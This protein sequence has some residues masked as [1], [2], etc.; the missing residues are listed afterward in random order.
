VEKQFVDLTAFHE[1]PQASAVIREI[2]AKPRKSL[3]AQ[4]GLIAIAE[5]LIVLKKQQACWQRTEQEYKTRIHESMMIEEQH[6]LPALAAAHSALTVASQDHHNLSL[7]QNKLLT[8]C[9]T[10]EEHRG[11]YDRLSKIAI[12]LLDIMEALK[13]GRTS[14]KVCI[15][16]QSS[17]GQSTD[18]NLQMYLMFLLSV[19][20]QL[21]RRY[22]DRCCPGAARLEF[23]GK[24]HGAQPS[25]SC[26]CAAYHDSLPLQPYDLFPWPLEDSPF[27]HQS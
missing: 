21:A 14:E 22:F 6:L 20:S 4:I 18:H 12:I 27:W 16:F 7:P 9:N 25:P 8:T 11:H 2:C 5:E 15:L 26:C 3:I 13:D 23:L 19:V 1:T 10:F 24:L 17:I